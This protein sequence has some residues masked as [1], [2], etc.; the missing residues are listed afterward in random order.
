VASS[1]SA[2]CNGEHNV[3]YIGDIMEKK[4]LLLIQ[5]RSHTPVVSVSVFAKFSI[6]IV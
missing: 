3:E 5:H 4:W 1:D 2:R 6:F